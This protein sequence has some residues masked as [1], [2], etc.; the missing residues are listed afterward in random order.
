MKSLP[1]IALLLSHSFA[2]AAESPEN[3]G[4]AAKVLDIFERRCTACHGTKSTQPKDFQYIDDLK[5]L[6]ESD[7][8]DL[9]VPEDSLIYE[10]TKEEDMPY[11]TKVEKKA[12]KKSP[13]PLTD[14]ETSLIL[15]WVRAGAPVPGDAKPAKL[16]T[17]PTTTPTEQT[18]TETSTS[19]TRALVTPADEITAALSDLQTVPREDQADIRYVSLA[20]QHNNAEI[21]DETL[22]NLRRGSRK[23]LNSLSTSPRI[24]LFPEVGPQKA[25]L[26]IN[27][28]DLGWDAALWDK[29]ASHF[30]QAIDTG[31]SS[32]LGQACHTTTPILRADWMAA[33][34]TRPPLYHDILRLPKTQQELER[35]LRVDV[36][37]NLTRGNALRSAFALSGVSRANR[38]VERHDLAHGGSYWL[39]YDFNA[40]GKRASLHQFPLGPEYANLLDGK[41]AFQ[42][43]GGE[44]VF[45]LPNG[46][47]A[48]YVADTL[49]NRLDGPAPTDIV[50]DRDNV[51][52]RGEIANGLSCIVCHSI[53]LKESVPKDEIR[54]LAA[55]FAVDEQRLI[56]QLYQDPKI[57][58]ARMKED[59]DSF[60]SAL[61]EARADP[62]KGQREPVGEL[63]KTFS[64]EVTL[65]KAAAELGLTPAALM[66]K[67]DKAPSL[68][69]LRI[70]FNRPSGSLQREHFIDRF[71]ELV[72]RLSNATVRQAAPIRFVGENKK[73]KRIR[74]VPVLLSLDKKTYR[75]GE[76]PR[77]HLEV[78]EDAHLR[79]LY[80]DARGD[81]TILFPNQF[82]K[83]DTVRA[84]RSL[85]MP[86]PNPTITGEEVAIEIWG[87]DN[88]KTFG[89]ERFIA[90]ATDQPFT[91]TA[92][93][94]AAAKEA[95]TNTG[96][97]FAHEKTRNLDL[98]ITKAARA[99][100]RP[101]A[102]TSNE[103]NFKTRVGI[104]TVTVTTHP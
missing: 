96:S 8:I 63:A 101:T 95:L 60:M 85:L 24:A 97:P 44:M 51:T 38:M 10:L 73:L 91:D 3:L 9:E 83:N 39:S 70:T 52:G 27:L 13:D 32:A 12:R 64:D 47:H 93:L 88:G 40:S 84:G 58:D 53:G 67:L 80:Q 23:M 30:P 56:E 21:D 86:T 5:K 48:Y 15:S 62:I 76:I 71:P 46:L 61:T 17:T 45:T 34:A 37:D 41:L 68:T 2:K 54:P 19:P 75:E 98:A 81:I 50:F 94:M 6:R 4:L 43:A 18:P 35:Q 79:L 49:G 57:F 31:I 90:I 36:K 102:T 11:L 26:R 104:S 100:S 33:D 14:T 74:P 72:T 66:A 55:T 29:V 77:I 22:E 16:A 28:R 82:I 103:K 1:L 78:A 69:D 20:P 92:A 65:E 59:I 89:T 42:H 99:I 25:L 87:G 7:L